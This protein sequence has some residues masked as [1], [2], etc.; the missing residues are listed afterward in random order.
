MLAA[1]ERM[2]ADYL[3]GDV[4]GAWRQFF[5]LAN[6]QVPDGVLEAMFGGERDPRVVADERFWFEHELRAS[7]RWRPDLSSLRYGGV[8]IV[9]GIG[10]ESAGQL[11]ERTTTALAAG[12]GIEPTRFPGDHIGFAAA[13]PTPF[14]VVLREVL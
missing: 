4:I 12:L 8:R 10:A 2:I 5:A 13:D 7:V 9:A 11:C 14:A 3:A 1:T 6:I